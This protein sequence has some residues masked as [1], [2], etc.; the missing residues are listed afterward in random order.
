MKPAGFTYH[1][2]SSLEAA[3]DI[4]FEVAPDGGRIIAG[5][6]SL[7]P[8]MALRVANPSH[9]VDINEIPELNSLRFDGDACIIGALTRHAQFEDT[10]VPA[11]L[12]A[13][14]GQ[15]CRQIAHYPI[16]ER[17]TFCGSIA[18]ADPSSEW[19]L[20]TATLDG[21]ILARNK[22]KE[23]LIPAREYF[24]GLMSTDLQA[25]EMVVEVRL[26]LLHPSD[27]FGFVEFTRR[28]GDLAMAMAL[29]VFN[30]KDGRMD[31]VRIGIGGA[32]AY[33][34]R[35]ELAEKLLTHQS[36]SESVFEAAAQ[37]AAESLDPLVDN[38]TDA[39]FR[40]D[41]VRMVVKRALQQAHQ[42]A[43]SL[44]LSSF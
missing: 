2:P 6:Q 8:M 4:L 3:L 32:E 28:A 25:D 12:G 33:P 34:R 23:R 7:V 36:P 21:F 10:L 13:L 31:N 20:V 27:K 1:R 22:F 42:D 39:E 11:P 44:A 15:V 40:K 18:L 38:Q 41:L 14:L 43:P 17:G 35:M 37:A 19:C 5:G 30:L 26:P 9:L 16:R 24:Q 29:V